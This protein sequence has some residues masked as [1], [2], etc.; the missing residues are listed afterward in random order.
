RRVGPR[1]RGGDRWLE[2]GPR[3][4]GAAAEWERAVD[5]SRRVPPLAPGHAAAWNNLGLLQHRR[6]RY[7]D[8]RR[9]YE[10]A[11]AADPASADAAYNLGSLHDDLGD[12]DRALL[13]YRRAL[14]T[15]PDYADP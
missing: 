15:H 3:G 8:A 11:L 4:A 9:H 1:E 6:G 5:A 12:V 14:E 10:V 13:C 2:R 7:E